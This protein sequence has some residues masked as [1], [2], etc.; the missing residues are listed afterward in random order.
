LQ[1]DD[2]YCWE[3]VAGKRAGREGGWEPVRA[4]N[5]TQSTKNFIRH[6]VDS[7]KI[8]APVNLSK[9]FSFE[10]ALT[11]PKIWSPEEIEDALTLATER[12]R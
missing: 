9:T 7:G 4:K 1:D 2:A 12:T 8:V 6:L 3:R 11:Q 10:K 5:R